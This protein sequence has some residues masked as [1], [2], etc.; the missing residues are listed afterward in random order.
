M[1]ISRA[2]SSTLPRA[3]RLR[4]SVRSCAGPM[5]LPASARRGSGRKPP[6]WICAFPRWPTPPSR[7]PHRDRRRGLPHPGRARPRPRAARLDC[8]S[9]SGLT[10][11][12]LKLDITPDLV[13]A[14]AAEVKAGEKAVTAAMAR[15]GHRAEDRLAQPDYRA[16]GSAGGSRTRSGARPIPKAGESLNAAGAGLVQGPGPSS[17]P[18]TPA[19]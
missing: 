6:G 17:A 19:R 1:R 7:R 10:A 14:M 5:T 15:S 12:K 8:G 3:A 2:T 9:A 16:R 13:V 4:W 11:M 18:T